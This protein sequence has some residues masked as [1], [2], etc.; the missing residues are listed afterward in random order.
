MRPSNANGICPRRDRLNNGFEFLEEADVV[1]EVVAEV[2]DLPLQHSYALKAHA[3]CE[4]AVDLRI[5][6]AG[7]EDVRVDHTAAEDLKP[8]CA[9][10]DVASLSLADVAAH[11][12]FG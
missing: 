3:E 10:A 7:A 9:L 5:N 12:N 8:A 6:A 4:A 11:V 1:L 2:L